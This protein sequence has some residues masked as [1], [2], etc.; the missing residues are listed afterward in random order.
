MLFKQYI[1]I[2]AHTCE[3]MNYIAY[4][5]MLKLNIFTRICVPSDASH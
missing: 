3:F 2:C 5:C 1:D 4:Y